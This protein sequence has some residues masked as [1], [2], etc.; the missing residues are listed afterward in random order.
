MEIVPAERTR[1]SPAL[2]QA[3]LAEAAVLPP[4]QTRLAQGLIR[5]F[6]APSLGWG[7]LMN[8]PWFI[9]LAN[10]LDVAAIA[11]SQ[12]ISAY[13]WSVRLPI[14]T[15]VSLDP[16]LHSCGGVTL[17]V[18]PEEHFATLWQPVREVAE[19]HAR[20]W[21]TRQ[22]RKINPCKLLKRFG[23][24]AMFQSIRLEHKQDASRATARFAFEPIELR[25][26]I[27]GNVAGAECFARFRFCVASILDALIA[28]WACRR[29]HSRR[30]LSQNAFANPLTP[31]PP[32]AHAP[33]P[34]A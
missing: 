34:T 33:F 23:Q 30:S 27:N 14:S 22:L 13:S 24:V 31:R 1:V 7:I 3:S 32:A 18:R 16:Q 6:R 26:V 25:L 21:I 5:R 17:L 8:F 19:V 9:M 15:G 12:V 10:E 28:K 4:P 20:V 29:R 11:P 2:S